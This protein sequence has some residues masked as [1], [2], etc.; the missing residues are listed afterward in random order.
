M[1]TDTKKHKK[2]RNVIMYWATWFVLVI[3]FAVSFVIPP[4]GVIDG[5]VLRAACILL[6]IPLLASMENMLAQLKNGQKIKVQH[7][8]LSAE[9]SAKTEE[10]KN[11]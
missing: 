7:G 4:T 9:V 5:S 1:S 11:T 6:S 2:Y 3:L 10:N 8:N